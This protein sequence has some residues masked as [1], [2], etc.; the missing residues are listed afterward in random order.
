[1][2]PAALRWPEKVDRAVPGA[3][4]ALL[5]DQALCRARDGPA[6]HWHGLEDVATFG[7]QRSRIKQ[8][9]ANA[10]LARQDEHVMY[11]PGNLGTC[12]LRE[13]A[14]SVPDFDNCRRGR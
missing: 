4:R 5:E 9:P 13:T 11:A 6:H 2:P 7:T 1:M 14:Y 12:G 10:G 3:V 8:G